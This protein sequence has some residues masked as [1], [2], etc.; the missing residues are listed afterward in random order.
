[1]RTSRREL[2]QNVIILAVIMAGLAVFLYPT[3]ADWFS[4]LNHNNAITEYRQAAGST[5]AAERS[6]ALRLADEYN[7]RMP[8]G[9]LRDPFA[10]ESASSD[11]DAG[12]SAYE[13]ILT[14]SE[15]GVMGRVKFEEVG[16]D[17]PIYHGTSDETISK[18]AGHLYGSSLP[19]GGPSTHSVLTA[20]SGLPNARLFTPLH[21]VELGDRFWVEVL[22]ERHWYVVENIAVVEANDLSELQIIEGEDYVTLFT[23]TPV[24]VN[25]HR[26]LVRGVRTE[27]PPDEVNYLQNDVSAGFPWWVIIFVG[28]AAGTSALLWGPGVVRRRKDAFSE[29]SAS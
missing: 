17:L 9:P 5:S 15:S 7:S 2:R 11:I 22:G 12:Y 14:V 29:Y 18:G 26:L 13:D 21:D 23:C 8:Q 16:I 19:V 25:S 6:E 28:S 4:R 27:T 1:M 24:G 3:A 20:H 10:Y